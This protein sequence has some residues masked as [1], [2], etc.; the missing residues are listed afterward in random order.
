MPHHRDGVDRN[1]VPACDVASGDVGWG[2]P[3]WRAND[4]GQRHERLRCGKSACARYDWGQIT[5]HGLLMLT[6]PALPFDA[7]SSDSRVV[8]CGNSSPPAFRRIIFLVVLEVVVANRTPAIRIACRR[9][10]DTR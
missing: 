3:D 7:S 10:P 5:H 9:W 2:E 4:P 1:A 6:L 8:R